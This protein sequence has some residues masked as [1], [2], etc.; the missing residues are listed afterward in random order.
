LNTAVDQITVVGVTESEQLMQAAGCQ[1]ID[2][3]ASI[4]S[5]VM[6]Q[7]ITLSARGK[8]FVYRAQGGRV[9]L[10]EGS[11]S[12]SG[13]P[14]EADA[15]VRA[16]VN[17][18]AS[19]R[20]VAAQAVQ[21]VSVEAV[22]WSDTSLGCPQPGM[23]YAQIIVRGFQIMLSTDGQPAEYHADVRGRVVTCSK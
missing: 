1:P 8:T 16:A 11:A 18:L 9:M 14:P 23:F 13:W 6:G 12:A 4:P 3:Q 7:D 10:C 22:D 5:I 20:K 21:I 19:K 15:A 17:D 2:A